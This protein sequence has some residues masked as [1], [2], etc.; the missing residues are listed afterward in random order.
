MQ[1]SEFAGCVIVMGKNF[2]ILL[3]R[4][5][6]GN[7]HL[8]RFLVPRLRPG[9][10]HPGSSAS[11]GLD[12]RAFAHCRLRGEAELQGDAFPGRSLGTRGGGRLRIVRWLLVTALFLTPNI[13]FADKAGD[14]FNLGVGLYRSQRYDQ[15]AETFERFL[16][17]FPDHPRTP[18]AR[19]YYGLSLSS[20]EKYAPAR[21]QFTAFLKSEP[22]VN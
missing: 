12:R 4:L 9:N 11:S 1:R 19:L 20:L 18:I 6:P 21:D 15:S 7:A 2:S 8:G 14:D 17:E 5:Q 22:D 10:G 3:A 13:A 16:T